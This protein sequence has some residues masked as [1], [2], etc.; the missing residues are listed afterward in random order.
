MATKKTKAKKPAGKK[1]A[2][3]RGRGRP[4]TYDPAKAKT[5][6]ERLSKGEP[7]AE[8][9]RSEGMPPVRTV[10]QWKA[11]HPEFAA[12]FAR[13]RDE[14]YDAIAA[15]C[16]V[17]ADDARN[18]WMAVHGEDDVGWR[19]NGEHVSRSKLRIETRLKL[20]AKWDPRRYGEK[21]HAE[22]TG[23]DGKDLPGVPAGVLVVPGLMA[24]TASWSQQ[25][26]AASLK[27]V[28]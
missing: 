24:D 22:L 27:G 3:K 28:E 9:C 4:S 15:D 10:S 8:I 12:D 11:D 23:K 26:Q 1:A 19:Q 5:I 7:L 16:M 14:G 17:I 18:D 25:A 6:C 21:V 2:P 20:L 13:A